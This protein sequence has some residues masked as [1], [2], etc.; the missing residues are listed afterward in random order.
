[1]CVTV[2]VAVGELAYRQP[3][4]QND[5]PKTNGRVLQFQGQHS[6]R[7]DVTGAELDW[8]SDILTIE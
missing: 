6:E 2:A 3:H 4:H 7:G 1:M 8:R 5:R